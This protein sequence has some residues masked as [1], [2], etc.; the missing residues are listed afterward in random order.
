MPVTE[1]GG[2][3]AQQ[4][5]QLLDLSVSEPHRRGLFGDDIT[6]RV[7][8]VEDGEVGF[9]TC[10]T[11]GDGFRNTEDAWLLGEIQFAVD[12]APD[13]TVTSTVTNN[14]Y[15]TW[16]SVRHFIAGEAGTTYVAAGGEIVRHL[17]DGTVVVAVDSVG[18][19][20]STGVVLSPVVTGVAGG[21]ETPRTFALAP[22]F[23][24]PFNPATEIRFRLP[25]NAHIRLSVHDITGRLVTVLTDGAHE[26]GEFALT[27]D[28]RDG[29]G[30]EAASGTYFA[31]L[32]AGNF[33][34]TR[35]MVLVR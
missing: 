10:D 23:P 5:K 21:S 15:E 13:G 18:A 35:K 30:R 11:D 25:E 31:R 24:N 6:F 28:G 22:N 7:V 33:T 12:R 26:S 9:F 8:R 19:L 20:S 29:A 2:I 27:W 1:G 17:P 14:H 32:T 4:A 3:D 16:R 34:A